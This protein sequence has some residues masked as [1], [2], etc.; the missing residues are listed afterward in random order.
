MRVHMDLRAAF[1]ITILVV[2]GCA[3]TSVEVPSGPAQLIP[4]NSVF[5][6]SIRPSGHHPQLPADRTEGNGEAEHADI[7]DRIRA[8]FAIGPLD[9]KYVAEYEKWYASRPKYMA[10]IVDRAEPYLHYIV[11]EVEKR[12]MPTEI[13]L[14]PAIESAFVPTAYS[15][16]HAVGLWQ[17]IPAT[18]RRYDIKRNWWYDGRQGVIESTRAAL[19]YLQFLHAEFNGNWFYAYKFVPQVT[20]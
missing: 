7:W 12:G 8:G 13:V 3:T 20:S 2:S 16:A 4:H 14:L 10:R 15:R 18:A 19:D 9:N 11:E 6:D 1:I 17:F 5:S